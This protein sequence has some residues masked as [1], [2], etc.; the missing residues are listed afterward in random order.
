MNTARSGRT[1]LFS[2]ATRNYAKAEP[3]YERALNIHKQ[4]LGSHHLRTFEDLADLAVLTHIVGG[5]SQQMHIKT[6]YIS[7][8]VKEIGIAV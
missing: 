8:S 3:L 1:S 4:A 6:A 2:R 5:T 7:D